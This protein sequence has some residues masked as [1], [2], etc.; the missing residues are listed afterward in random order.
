MTKFQLQFQ[1]IS[2]LLKDLSV[3]FSQIDFL[4]SLTLS[5]ICFNN[6]PTK[7]ENFIN[8]QLFNFTPNHKQGICYKL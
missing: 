3:T 2:I 7:I 4:G 1:T 6:L 8:N 5:T